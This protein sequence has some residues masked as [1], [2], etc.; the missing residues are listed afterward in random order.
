ME[1]IVH[2]DIKHRNIFL[3][4]HGENPKVKIADFGLAIFLEDDECI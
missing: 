3:N 1:Q 4:N 2:G